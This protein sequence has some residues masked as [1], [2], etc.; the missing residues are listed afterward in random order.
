MAISADK[1]VLDKL[2]GGK[3]DSS[4]YEFTLLYMYRCFG[5]NEVLNMPIP[6]FM[7]LVNFCKEHDKHKMSW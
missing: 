1:F 6:V 7:K 2:T 5:Y 3:S 4:D